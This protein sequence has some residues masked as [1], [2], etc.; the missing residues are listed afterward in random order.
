MSLNK[1]DYTLR[2][3]VFLQ[4]R[5]DKEPTDCYIDEIFS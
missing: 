3:P 4:V 1:K 5:Q 2:H